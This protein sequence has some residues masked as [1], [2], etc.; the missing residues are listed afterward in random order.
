MMSFGPSIDSILARLVF[1][2]P[3]A[4]LAQEVLVICVFIASFAMWRQWN[5]DK[6]ALQRS[7]AKLL[8]ETGDQVSQTLRK[9]APSIEKPKVR[10][11]PGIKQAE[12]QMRKHL[13]HREFTRA[14]NLYR[15]FERDGQD[16]YFSEELYA[17]FIESA[18]R[19]GKI[20]V[21]ER[22][23]S[24][25][26][27]SGHA[28]TLK[29]W[30]TT[31]RML[32]SRKHFAAC[33]H[34]HQL[35]GKQI[36]IDKVI[37]SCL[38]N[39]ALETGVPERAAS[40]LGRYG[41]AQLDSKDY[42]L[43]FRTYVAIG[44]VDE[45]E[46]MFR[47]LGSQATTLMFNLLLSTCVNAKQPGRA[48]KLLH[49][50]H[51]LKAKEAEKIV[52]VVSYNTVIKGFAQAS[53]SAEC[54]EC[55]HEM[56]AHDLEPDDITLGTLIDTCIMAG[57][58]EAVDLLTKNGKGMD[59]VTS[60]VLIKGLVRGGNLPSA[61]EIYEEMKLNNG[62][63][64][65]IITYS[66]VIK[67]LVDQHDLQR[68]LGLVKDMKGAGLKPD[69]IIMTHLL[70]GCRHANNHTLGKQL[71]A[72]MI[73][74]GVKPSEVTLVT[75]LKLHGRCGAHQEAF[76]LVAGW[77]KEY[78]AKPSVIHFTCLMSGC[79]RTKSYEQAWQAYSSMIASGVTPDET[80][81]STLLPGMVAAQQWERIII[82]AEMAL[83]GP[84]KMRIPPETMNN[85]LAQMMAAEGS[86]G[87][88]TGTRNAARLQALM[89]EAKV[90]I[91]V[92]Q[93]HRRGF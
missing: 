54:I 13:E 9:P 41:Q 69:D 16:V 83:K 78:G 46:Q 86:G 42:V 85:A 22:M 73:A 1:D 81:V 37:I 68:A 6:S 24:T 5:R 67:A 80:L 49:E 34:A 26:H 45:A 65:D 64:P 39:A 43:F 70:E 4:A 88:K 8:R 58:H 52:D 2:D 14:L 79:L 51:Q 7:K 84:V 29:F 10:V 61:M 44:N 71:F 18:I 76:D 89:Q 93:L 57:T 15:S 55:L 75:M 31:L 77:E 87:A 17:A 27:R 48:H 25:L 72:E 53:M 91:T 32:S 63:H 92:R 82:L 47:K 50:A 35:F 28:P 33:L 59:T 62:S 12:E 20:D 11:H 30:Q 60:T 21:V 74:S 40:M 90:P 56:R 19:V 3:I 38:I 36:P 66:I 23:L